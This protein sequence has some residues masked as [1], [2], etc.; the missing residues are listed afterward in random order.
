MIRLIFL[1]LVSV[2]TLCAYYPNHFSAPLQKIAFGSCNKEYLPQ[3]LWDVIHSNQPDLWIWIGDNIYGDSMDPLIVKKRYEQQTQHRQY[4]SFRESVPII[5]TWDDHD[6]GWNHAG[7]EYPAKVETRELA[8]DFLEYPKNHPIREREGL[9]ATHS[10]GPDGRQVQVILLDGRYFAQREKP[11]NTALL[12]PK[13]NDWLL[14][15]IRES[16]AEV[17]LI[18]SSIQVIPKDHPYEK[19]ANFPNARDW[20]LELLDDASLP[21]TILLSGDRHFHEMSQIA[22]PVSG[23]TLLEM[24]SSGLTHSWENLKE[25]ANC[26]RI[27]KFYNQIGFGMLQFEWNH[28][29]VSIRAE[30]RNSINNAVLRH[31]FSLPITPALSKARN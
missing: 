18:V 21:H 20:L 14:T 15:T 2:Q 19:W 11:S 25:E 1:T 24:T 6:Y 12:G 23:R 16:T 22:L 13:Q 9:Y 28:R 3:P 29:T 8:L 17:I 4:Q 27:G 31:D 10:F 7:A 26:Y 30:I 5:G